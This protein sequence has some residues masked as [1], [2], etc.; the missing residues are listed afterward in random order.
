MKTV[1]LV[2][3]A[4]HG[5]WCWSAV[6]S[7]LRARGYTVFTPTQT[8][9][10]ERSHLLSKSVDLEVFITD[11]LNVFKW[12]DLHDV[13]LVGHSF[14]GAVIS[15]VADRLHN[16]VRQLVY[17]D[18]VILEHGQS[19]LS[20][21]PKELA[22]A[23][24]KQSYETSDGLSIPPP[25]AAAFGITDPSQQL[26]VASRLTPHPLKTYEAPVKLENPVGNG[27]PASYVVCTNPIYE[28][29]ET[30]RKRVKLAA[31][32]MREIRSGHDAMVIAPEQ[33]AEL[34]ETKGD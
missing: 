6:A 12:E 7:I 20:L 30:S 1:V 21:L 22:E 11:I 5:G 29:L 15:G 33:V 16:R 26:F 25:P 19:P 32:K 3:G 17:L 9:L 13:M 27:I 14:G 23:R 8:G 28:P 24:R 18:A 34:L 31:W 2:H 4:W 10:G